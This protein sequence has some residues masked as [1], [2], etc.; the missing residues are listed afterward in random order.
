MQSKAKLGLVVTSLLVAA[1]GSSVNDSN[2]NDGGSRVDAQQP[3][4][5][6][7]G[8]TSTPKPD[9]E[10]GPP[11]PYPAFLPTNPPQVV[12]LG[13]PVMASPKIVPIFFATDDPST[14]AKIADFVAKVG[15]TKYW[16]ANVAEYGGGAATGLPPIQLTSADNPPATFDDSSIQLWLANKLNSNDPAFPAPDE[17]TLYALF[18][19]PGVTITLGG[20][21]TPTGDG[22]VEGGASDAGTDTG[23]GG[24]GGFGGVE[25]SCTDF[26]GY[27]ENITLD[28]AHGGA[29]ASLAVIPRCATFGMLTG[30]D[31][32]T[33][34]GSHEFIEAATD[35]Q[36][37]AIPAYVQIDT[38]H[39]YWER[40]LGGG[41][42]CDMCAQFPSSFTKFSE[43]P[44]TVQ[45][46]WSNKAEKAGT[47]PCVPETTGEVYF[48]AYPEL[49]NVTS[50][51]EGMT[52]TVL[53]VDIP[54][55]SSKV[56]T[57]D[58]FSDGPTQPWTVSAAGLGGGMS[59][60][61]NLDFSFDK[62]TGQNGDKIQMT[63]KVTAA[64][65]RNHEE[66]IVTSTLG[67]AQNFW[68][69]FVA[70]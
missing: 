33:G 21:P 9:A 70:N 14:T 56:V 53:G 22:G 68:V 45:R 3:G 64:S 16:L 6:A 11:L 32:I 43:L 61:S 25:S 13:G 60:M 46:C 2:A 55:G 10:A 20:T 40:V 19:P 1:C 65:M 48:N 36:P 50:S 58:L 28:S 54:V 63:I 39:E 69:G 52:T 12:S 7:A 26:G 67:T 18:Y 15:Q 41:E 30:L 4:H 57:L 8:D 27:H 31:V 47:D 34:A 5:D 37:Y 24:G 49:G 17:N 35:P 23:G 62:T 44:Y 59:M 66:F 29:Y 42:V 38:P 51:V